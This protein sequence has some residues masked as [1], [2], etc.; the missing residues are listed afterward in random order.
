[1]KNFD[2]FS[3]YKRE[4]YM[5]HMRDAHIHFL[6]HT[7]LF[8]IRC[9][10]VFWC[11]VSGIGPTIFQIVQRHMNVHS[12]HTR[13]L[14]FATQQARHSSKPPSSSTSSSLLLCAWKKRISRFYAFYAYRFFFSS[15][16]KYLSHFYNAMHELARV[17]RL[18]ESYGDD[19]MQL[20]ER[21]NFRVKNHV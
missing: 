2:A 12:P 17:L 7:W 9:R 5:L 3:Q 19:E 8:F 15:H 13:F 21:C 14:F 4:P 1:M 11:M 10:I 6:C 18:L 20:K 16:V